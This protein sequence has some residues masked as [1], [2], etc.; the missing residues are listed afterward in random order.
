MNGV[1]LSVEWVITNTGGILDS[2]LSILDEKN[3]KLHNLISICYKRNWGRRVFMDLYG[4]LN[5][6]TG[7]L[8]LKDGAGAF[9]LITSFKKDHDTVE[10]SLIPI[11]V[12]DSYLIGVAKP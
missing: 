2:F 10:D 9:S 1:V 5:M 11:D 12:E 8:L 3:D 4:R 7:Y 6:Q